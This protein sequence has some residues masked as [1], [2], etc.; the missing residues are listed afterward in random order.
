MRESFLEHSNKITDFFDDLIEFMH[1]EHE[2]DEYGNDSGQYSMY[3]EEVECVK[4]SVDHIVKL[5]CG[6]EPP[7]AGA[8]REKAT[9]AEAKAHAEAKARAEAHIRLQIT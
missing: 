3:I 9:C 8:R 4:K 5:C 1:Y 2:D 7:R 6:A